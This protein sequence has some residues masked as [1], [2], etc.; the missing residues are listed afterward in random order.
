LDDR[1]G[2]RRLRIISGRWKGRRLQAPAG[3]AV[4][5]TSD[6]L[7]ETLFNVLG[8]GIAGARVLDAFAG[9]GALGLEALSRGAAHVIFVERDR[10]AIRAL[11]ANVKAC[12]A[13]EACAI[14]RHD[15]TAR[16]VRH[17]SP[18]SFDLVLLDP[19]YDIVD[20]DAPLTV[21][22]SLLAR[23]GRL[24]LEH[25]RRR[26]TPERVAALERVRLLAA[27]DSGLSFYAPGTD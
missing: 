9:T 4:R 2:E 3:Q 16:A 14:I 26:V 13:E 27:G 6:R 11:E 19:P 18:G 21:G 20:L 25:R 8:P 24:V 15:F 23:E 1:R 17:V 7:R 10:R 5:P 12:G 22:A